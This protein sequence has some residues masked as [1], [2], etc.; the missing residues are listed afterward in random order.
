MINAI[1]SNYVLTFPI[2]IPEIQ[3]KDDFIFDYRIT[4]QPNL[5]RKYL[6]LLFFAELNSKK[7]SCDLPY[8]S[9]HEFEPKQDMI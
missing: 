1:L 6:D 4:R 3:K 7:N 9:T 5:T 2:E 8:T